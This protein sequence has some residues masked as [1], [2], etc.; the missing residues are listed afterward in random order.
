MAFVFSNDA[1][2]A[3]IRQTILTEILGFLLGMLETKLLEHIL[4]G[5]LTPFILLWAGS[6]TSIGPDHGLILVSVKLWSN[7]SK[8]VVFPLVINIV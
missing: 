6:V 7:T 4:I 8:T 3:D 5:I 2:G 1:L